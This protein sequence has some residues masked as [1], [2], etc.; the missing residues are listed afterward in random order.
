VGFEKKRFF[1]AK[2]REEVEKMRM[3]SVPTMEEGA[4]GD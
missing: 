4:G 2:N 1:L 3:T